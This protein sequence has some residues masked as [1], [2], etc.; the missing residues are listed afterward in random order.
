MIINI[1][2][3]TGTI[4]R[5]TLNLIDKNF[6]DLKINLLV[7]KSNVILLRKQI[8]KYKPKYVFIYDKKKEIC[9]SQK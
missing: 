6:T 1:F 3:S 2:G 4:G 5:K 8:V 7:V 9:L